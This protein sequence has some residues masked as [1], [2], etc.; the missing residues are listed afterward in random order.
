M[1]V[2]VVESEGGA[3]TALLFYG[4]EVMAEGTGQTKCM[5]RVAVWTHGLHYN[6][7]RACYFVYGRVYNVVRHTLRGTSTHI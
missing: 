1:A 7:A 6:M 3:F 5:R 4:L 2:A